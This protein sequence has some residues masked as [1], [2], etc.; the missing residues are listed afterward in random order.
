MIDKQSKIF[1]TGHKGMVG[2]ATLSLLKEKG[3]TSLITA[4]KEELDL[5]SQAAVLEFFM[6]HKP[7]YVINAAARVGGINANMK[8]PATYVYDNLMIQTNVIHSSYKTD[9]K[10]IVFLGSSCIYPRECPQ[11]MKEEYLLTGSLEPTNEPYAVAKISGIKMLESYWKQYGLHCAILMPCNLYGPNDSFDLDKAHVLS[12]LIKRFVDAKDRNEPFV[13]AWG[14]GA[15]KREFLHVKDMARAVLFLF[16]NYNSPYF[17]N[18]GSGTD[19]SIKD[20]ANVIAKKSG[21]T[22][23]IQWDTSKPDGM[24]RKCMDISKLTQLGFTPEVSLEY[25]IE[26]LIEEYKFLK[27]NQK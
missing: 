19:I 14:T 16:E 24:P 10:K 5:T 27:S 8:Y 13:T 3:Y 2:S 22:G 12:S 25:G 18:V 20:L 23:E 26:Q 11:P 1:I 9:V 4:T 15:A 21:F 17:I 6:K 7:D